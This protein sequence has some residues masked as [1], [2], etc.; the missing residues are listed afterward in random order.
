MQQA[1]S[2]GGQNDLYRTAFALLFDCAE[3][4]GSQV[5]QMFWFMQG[6]DNISFSKAA[7]R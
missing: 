6:L 1:F 5:A 7:N 4:R 2:L 3:I